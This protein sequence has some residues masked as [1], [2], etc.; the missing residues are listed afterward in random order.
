M[1]KM[2]LGVLRDIICYITD[3]F[4]DGSQFPDKTISIVKLLRVIVTILFKSLVYK[5][6]S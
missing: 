2:V 3:I 1:M 6:F 5:N 4:S